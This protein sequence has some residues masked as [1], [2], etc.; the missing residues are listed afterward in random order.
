[1]R[2]K[3]VDEKMMDALVCG[4]LTG[5]DY[6]QTIRQI[7]A[8]PEL[9]RDCGLA[10][11]REQAVTQAMR[12]M[13]TQDRLWQPETPSLP[14]SLSESPSESP[15]ESQ[16][17]QLP[18]G[19]LGEPTRDRASKDV[20]GD[21][22]SLHPLGSNAASAPLS[23]V[24]SGD[25]RPA[26]AVRNWSANNRWLASAGLAAS[27]LLGFFLGQFWNQR[28]LSKERFGKP[29]ELV[30]AS[31]GSEILTGPFEDS[32]R[33]IADAASSRSSDANLGSTQESGFN[34]DSYNKMAGYGNYTGQLLPIDLPI[35][36]RLRELERQGKIRIDSSSA[37][38]PVYGN[39]GTS[40]IVPVQQLQIVPVVHSY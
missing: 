33:A 20:F 23:H 34:R 35:P 32:T 1:M 16:I 25:T 3:K 18:A 17:S 19:P 31:T 10:F 9:W 5:E 4:E 2:V 36:E 12:Q 40:F 21:S 28:Q 38:L 13:A 14:E 8:N 29:T 7:E 15:S 6:R 30:E 37:V 39:D 27:A 22:T 11:L 24:D 26:R